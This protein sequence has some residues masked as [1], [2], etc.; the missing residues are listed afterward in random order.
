MVVVMVV[1]M[2][3]VFFVVETQNFASLTMAAGCHVE[4]S[5]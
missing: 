4:W 5:D 2:V 1:A 3:V